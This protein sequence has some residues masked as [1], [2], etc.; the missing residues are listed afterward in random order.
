MVVLK[1]PKL[2]YALCWL[3]FFYLGLF[4]SFLFSSF[5]SNVSSP[6]SKYFFQRLKFS[7]VNGNPISGL[8]QSLIV[9]S[10]IIPS[11]V[12]SSWSQVKYSEA[13]SAK[14]IVFQCRYAHKDNVS[15]LLSYQLGPIF[16]L[17]LSEKSVLLQLS[18]SSI[19]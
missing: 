3:P 7:I 1:N 10:I 11:V 12:L 9:L 6:V 17:F 5:A 13:T 18:K 16:S 8:S 2:A 14:A 15:V 4:N 19:R